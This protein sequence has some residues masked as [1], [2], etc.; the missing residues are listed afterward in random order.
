MMH[1]T[2]VWNILKT[3]FPATDK[4]NHF[5]S[6]DEIKADSK[7]YEYYWFQFFP[8]LINYY[9]FIIYFIPYIL[10]ISGNSEAI[11]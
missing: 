3:Y 8:Q 4:Y 6:Y 11:L 1:K 10:K 5:Y 9:F 7:E 2:F